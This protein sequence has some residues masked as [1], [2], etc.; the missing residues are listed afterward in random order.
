[1]RQRLAAV[2]V[3]FVVM[4]GPASS[5]RG[6]SKLSASAVVLGFFEGHADQT[7][8]GFLAHIRPEP[9]T[10]A[11]QAQVR[12]MLP[13]HGN[14]RPS[15]TEGAKIAAA[16]RMLDYNAPNGVITIQVIDLD[17][18][19]VGLYFRTVILVSRQALA[20]VNR[21]EFAALVAHELGHDYDWNDYWAAMQVHDHPRMQQLELRADAIAVLIL[22][23]LGIAPDRL[24]TAVEKVTRHNERIGALAT[25]ED[26]VPLK[27]RLAFIR[28]MKRL[29]WADAPIDAR[30]RVVDRGVDR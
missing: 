1:M 11:A 9:L 21:E 2:T 6:P 19:F 15:P 14:L 5:A 10:A 17:H 4:A 28:A 22:R 18:A 12:A 3:C 16:E 23:R 25:A 13:T 8:D 20:S 7:I 24:V 27:E 26:Y 30:S 29:A